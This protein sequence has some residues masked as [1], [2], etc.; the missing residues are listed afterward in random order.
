MILVVKL[1]QYIT[2]LARKAESVEL[3]TVMNGWNTKIKI[4]GQEG[5]RHV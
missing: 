4:A 1:S 3:Q 5:Q 2:S